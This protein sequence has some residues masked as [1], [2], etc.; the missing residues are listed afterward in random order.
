MP[1]RR[2]GDVARLSWSLVAIHRDALPGWQAFLMRHSVLY[3]HYRVWQKANALES[4]TDAT[5][6]DGN[7]SCLFHARRATTTQSPESEDLVRVARAPT[8][9]PKKRRRLL[10][11]IAPPAFVVDQSR[12]PPTFEV[13]GLN[14]DTAQLTDPGEKAKS[15]LQSAESPTAIDTCIAKRSSRGSAHVFSVR[16]SLTPA[17]HA[18]VTDTIL[19]C[20]EQ[21]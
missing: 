16:W 9:N 1:L 8:R 19:A 17:G 7:R 6:V 12:M 3:A 14:P 18:V 11:A 13:V 21:Q 15:L 20:M 4:G 10:V 5:A 2:K